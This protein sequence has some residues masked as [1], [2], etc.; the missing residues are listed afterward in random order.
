MNCVSNVAL[1]YLIYLLAKVTFN[2]PAWF[3]LLHPHS[4]LDT[5]GVLAVLGGGD[6]TK[7]PGTD[8]LYWEL[9]C[10]KFTDVFEKPGTTPEKAIK[11]E[12]DLLPDFVPHAE[13]VQ[14]ITCGTC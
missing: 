3:G 9:I 11:H 5:K 4:L 1:L 7:L 8:P 13:V 10:S 6:S 14:N 2:C 12:I